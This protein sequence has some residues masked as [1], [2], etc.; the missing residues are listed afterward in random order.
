MFSSRLTVSRR[1]ASERLSAKAI[2]GGINSSSQC[3]C[4]EASANFSIEKNAFAA[5]SGYRVRD[6]WWATTAASIHGRAP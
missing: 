3:S 2:N 1:C 6:E 4:A 5:A